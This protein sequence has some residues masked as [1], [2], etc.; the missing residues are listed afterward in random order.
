MCGAC[1]EGTASGEGAGNDP[2]PFSFTGYIM[3]K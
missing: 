1:V 2:I 3:D